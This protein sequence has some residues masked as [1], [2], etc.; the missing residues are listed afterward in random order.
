MLERGESRADDEALAAPERAVGEMERPQNVKAQTGFGNERAPEAL[1]DEAERLQNGS[2][3]RVWTQRRRTR[4]ASTAGA[5]VVGWPQPSS[6]RQRGDE[7]HRADEPGHRDR[8]E[9]IVQAA[10]TIAASCNRGLRRGRHQYP[11]V[12]RLDRDAVLDE[13]GDGG[14]FGSHDPRAEDAILRENSSSRCA[15]APPRLDERVS[16][17]SGHRF[18]TRVVGQH[19]VD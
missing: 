18:A 3:A 15:S 19:R 9:R 13:A 17:G 2:C 8:D 7:D 12:S 4:S 6:S 16:T 5:L 1:D 11:T 14:R 10:L